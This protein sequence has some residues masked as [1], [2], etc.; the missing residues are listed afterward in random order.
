M[1]QATAKPMLPVVGEVFAFPVEALNGW[2]LAQV[3]ETFAYDAS[4]RVLDDPDGT[5]LLTLAYC[6]EITPLRPALEDFARASLLVRDAYAWSAEPQI[7][8]VGTEPPSDYFS[9][10]IAAPLLQLEERC[11]S[12]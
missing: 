4:I 7:V 1:K 10:G 12:W 9:L 11:Q 2:G 8:N 5:P 3:V 6:H